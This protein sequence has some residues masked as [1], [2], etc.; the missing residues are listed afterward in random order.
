MFSPI[1]LSVIPTQKINKIMR[2][3]LQYPAWLSS[4]ITAQKKPLPWK[5][6][7]KR[8]FYIAF[9]VGYL[10][11]LKLLLMTWRLARFHLSRQN[12]RA[13]W[14]IPQGIRFKRDCYGVIIVCGI[15]RV[16]NRS[17]TVVT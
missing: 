11:S 4:R 1:Y 15:Q 14:L 2:I 17:R 10:Y 9:V 8:L 3:M 7:Q 6:P 5:I 16:I 13:A 12:H